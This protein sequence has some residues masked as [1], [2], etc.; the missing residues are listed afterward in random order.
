MK[1]VLAFALTVIIVAASCVAGYDI[2]ADDVPPAVRTAFREKYPNAII[3]EWEVEKERGRLIYEAE[4]TIDG[5]K[6]EALFKSDGTF[7]EED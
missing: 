4:F 6:K 3:N 7:V 2:V 1:Y 5:K